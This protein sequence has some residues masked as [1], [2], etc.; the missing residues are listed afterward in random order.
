MP[1]KS[2]S[3]GIS[4]ERY[5]EQCSE[6][7][8]CIV[9][10]ENKVPYIVLNQSGLEAI[11]QLYDSPSICAFEATSS[12]PSS[13]RTTA[14]TGEAAMIPRSKYHSP[15]V[16]G[17][18]HEPLNSS[19]PLVYHNVFISEEEWKKQINNPSRVKANINAHSCKEKGWKGSHNVVMQVN[20]LMVMFFE[21]LPYSQLKTL[22][23]DTGS[24]NTFLDRGGRVTC[25]K[26]VDK[27]RNI[28]KYIHKIYPVK[29]QQEMRAKLPKNVKFGVR[30]PPNSPLFNNVNTVDF[31]RFKGVIRHE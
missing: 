20:A 19:N 9:Y 2:T 22:S 25:I 30:I 3:L 8:E 15:S 21:F 27:P 13:Q 23:S 17:Y 16:C 6:V 14:T 4:L 5:R 31:F 29:L 26:M 18:M 11:L 7:M 10:L 28:K 24:L 1:A 12:P